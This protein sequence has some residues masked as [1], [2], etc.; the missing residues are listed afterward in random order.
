MLQA[1][2]LQLQADQAA[3]NYT[4]PQGLVTV[5]SALPDPAQRAKLLTKSLNHL[6]YGNDVRTFGSNLNSH[7][8]DLLAE[9]I[10]TLRLS[11]ENAIQVNKAL[12]GVRERLK[13]S[14]N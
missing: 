5:A 14:G 8:V 2:D 10:E 3:T 1:S 4:G 12:E 6:A 9:R 13:N 7:D 11:G